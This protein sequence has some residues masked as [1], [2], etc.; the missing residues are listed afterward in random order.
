M[1]GIATSLFRPQDSYLEEVVLLLSSWSLFIGRPFRPVSS[2]ISYLSRGP[3]PIP[4]FPACPRDGT[5][6]ARSFVYRVWRTPQGFP[7]LNVWRF[8]PTI[9]YYTCYIE[10]FFEQ[11]TTEKYLTISHYK[12]SKISPFLKNRY[13]EI[14][15]ILTLFFMQ[16]GS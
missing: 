8:V 15:Q 6:Q 7:N 5:N 9:I 2:L 12:R 11:S 14:Y 10:N 3:Y 1:Y 4:S 13:C 16:P